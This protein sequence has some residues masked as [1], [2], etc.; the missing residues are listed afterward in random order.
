MILGIKYLAVLTVLLTAID[1][2]AEPYTPASDEDVLETLTLT[3]D[4][5]NQQS[6]TPIPQPT[7]INV[8]VQDA[9]ADSESKQ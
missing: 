6:P 3:V 2:A 8:T 7:P 9:A 1:A 5:L 4:P